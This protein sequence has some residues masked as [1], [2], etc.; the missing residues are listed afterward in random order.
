VTPRSATSTP[1]AI[2][3]AFARYSTWS[4]RDNVDLLDVVA[5][6]D[7]GDI[8]DPDDDA[9]ADDIANGV[10]QLLANTDL[11]MVLGG[12]NAVTWHVLR[13]V[14]PREPW[15]LITLD[16]HLDLRDGRSNGSPVAQLLAEGLDGAHVVQVGLADFSNSAHYA[17]QGRAAGIT[18]I[19][20]HETRSLSMAEVAARALAIAGADN[21]PIYVDIDVDAAD[22]SVVPG[23]PAAAP[24]GFSADEMRQFV[25]AV[26]SHPNVRCIDLTEIDV[27]RDAAD[28]R[29]VRLAALLVLEAM[30]GL[31][32]RNV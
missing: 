31:A 7:F 32:K 12:D 26:T 2:R 19:S 23:C 17:A 28:E 15:G 21:R 6:T 18:T 16:A 3:Q 25:Y 11:A 10:N 22:R 4:Y 30:A 14:L 9:S 20:R 1:A 24:G 27:D 8:T 29:T 13:Q 5:A